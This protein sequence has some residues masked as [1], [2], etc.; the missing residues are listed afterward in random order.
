MGRVRTMLYPDERYP[1]DMPVHDPMCYECGNLHDG[2][3]P[4]YLAG[5]D[6]AGWVGIVVDEWEPF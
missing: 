2:E 6:N 4:W 5:L 1:E 3:C